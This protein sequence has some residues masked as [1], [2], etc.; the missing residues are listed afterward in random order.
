[1]PGVAGHRF[2]PDDILENVTRFGFAI[3]MKSTFRP[4]GCL[5]GL[6]SHGVNAP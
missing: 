5:P 2:R 6:R 3:P 1:M 4:K